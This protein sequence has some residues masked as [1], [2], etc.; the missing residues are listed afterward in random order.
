ML[1]T[2]SN[3]QILVTDG[4][5]TAFFWP[6]PV[7]RPLIH[8]TVHGF[9]QQLL[10]FH[11]DKHSELGKSIWLSR[12]TP[13]SEHLRPLPPQPCLTTRAAPTSSPSRT[14]GQ[15]SFPRKQEVQLQVPTQRPFRPGGIH[16]VWQ[17]VPY[18]FYKFFLKA[19]LTINTSWYGMSN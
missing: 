14:V 17:E 13:N 11:H 8:S 18:L 15:L 1:S 19:V 5:Q 9:T 4:L 7:S 2:P 3:W 16:R 6:V 10:L 12:G